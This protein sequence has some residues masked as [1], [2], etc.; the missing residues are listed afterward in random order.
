MNRTIPVKTMI[1]TVLVAIILSTVGGTAVTA[2]TTQNDFYVSAVQPDNQVDK[3]VSYFDLRMEPSAKQRI[4]VD[5]YN[6][7]NEE[8]NVEVNAVNASSN[9]NGIIDYTKEGIKHES[10]KHPFEN[11]ARVE[12]ET[13]KVEPNSVQ[14][15]PI[16]LSMPAEEFD[17][18]VLGGLVFTEIEEEQEQQ[19]TE[20]G[21]SIENEISYAIAVKLTENN[22]VV[23][24][25]LAFDGVDVNTERSIPELTHNIVNENSAMI[26]NA[27]LKINIR[28]AET[29]Q[30]EI[31]HENDNVSMAPNS[32]MPYGL[33]ISEYELEPGDYIS[34]VVFEYLDS[35]GEEQRATFEGN[36][37]ITQDNIDQIN[38]VGEVGIPLWAKIL[39]GSLVLLAIALLILSIILIK[40]KRNNEK[41]H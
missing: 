14:R 21:L 39:I 7:K 3:N 35:E 27:N 34:R 33:N 16:E 18:L 31:S 25:K 26:T 32:L 8:L 12:N 9:S 5:V 13:I 41:K 2:E 19:S 29:N 15:V 10:L 38:Q 11:I 23:N 40:N 1:V 22:E 37:T 6:D 30:N 17:G 4:F 24:P 36:F 28:N 20:D